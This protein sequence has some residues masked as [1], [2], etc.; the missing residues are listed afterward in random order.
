MKAVMNLTRK[1]PNVAPVEYL[2]IGCFF[3]VFLMIGAKVLGP[4]I[5]TDFLVSPASA[6]LGKG[7]G[8]KL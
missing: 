1:I 7:A 4:S 3:Y 5:K 6:F 8:D 2:I